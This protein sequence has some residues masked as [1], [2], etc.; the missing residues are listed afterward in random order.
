M[1]WTV[2]LVVKYALRRGASSRTDLINFACEAV[3]AWTSVFQAFDPED[4]GWLP[5]DDLR[6]A[7]AECGYD[8]C[9]APL[10]YLRE[11]FEHDGRLTLDGFIKACALT[12][13]HQR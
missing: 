10:A 7:I 9:G 1:P 12:A 6:A 5:G 4:V 11:V 13:R 2:A 8:V 3:E